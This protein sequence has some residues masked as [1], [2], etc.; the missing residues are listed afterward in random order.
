MTSG[1]HWTTKELDILLKNYG[2]SGSNGCM[3]LLPGRSRQAI[4]NRAKKAGLKSPQARAAQARTHKDYGAP[5]EHGTADFAPIVR[6]HVP[7]GAWR[8]DHPITAPSVF[9]LGGA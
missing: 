2:R 9:Q 3:P 6:R 5:I 8:V 4:I 7:I 1:L